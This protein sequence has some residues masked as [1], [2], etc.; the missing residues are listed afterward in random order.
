MATPAILAKLQCPKCREAHW[1]IDNEFRGAALFGGTE[2]AWDQRDYTCPCC[3]Y[4]GPGYVLGE[5]SPPEFFLQ[6]HPMYPMTHVD[7]EYW[8][9]VLR[10]HFPN[11]PALA[12]LGTT[13]YPGTE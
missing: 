11:N 8:V 2:Q 6:P 1:L 13:W 4:E 10:K 7:F 9:N 5:T 3:G 12:D